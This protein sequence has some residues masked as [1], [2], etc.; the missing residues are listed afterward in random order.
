MVQRR[1]TDERACQRRKL[2]FLEAGIWLRARDAAWPTVLCNDYGD[3]WT[4]N[5]VMWARAHGCTSVEIH[6]DADDDEW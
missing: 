5:M 4:E 6:G 1:S 2:R 3:S